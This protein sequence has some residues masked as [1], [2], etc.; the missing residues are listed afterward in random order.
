MS[1]SKMNKNVNQKKPKDDKF[2]AIPVKK[3]TFSY[4][5]GRGLA[6]HKNDTQYLRDEQI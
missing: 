6:K 2:F 1:R 3:N 4:L 5:N